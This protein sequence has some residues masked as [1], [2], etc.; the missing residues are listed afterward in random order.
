[1]K[2]LVAP[3]KFK[4][5]LTAPQAAGAIRRGLE[6]A[7]AHAQCREMPIAD[8]GE[9]TAEVLCSA[10]AGRWTIASA[11][12]PIGRPIEAGYAWLPGGTAVIAM[13][14]ASGLW[15]VP[16]DKRDILRA[17]TFGT[18]ELMAHA[19]AR[20]ARKIMLGL[21]G[22]ATN[23]GGVGAAA[24]CG[25][26][27]MD[28]K[29]RPVDPLPVAFPRLA[30]VVRPAGD[31]PEVVAM[32]DVTNPLLGPR[33][34]TWTYGPQKGG[35]ARTL[36]LLEEALTLL[37]GVVRKDL[38]HNFR[39]VPGAGAA[40]GMGFGLMSFF[41]ARICSG[42]ET[43]AAAIGLESAILESDLV[44]TGEGCLDGQTLEGKGPAGVA[45]LARKNGRPV[46]G[47]AGRICD[48]DDLRQ[49]FDG[50]YSIK[51]D[52]MPLEVAIREAE[53]L[54]ELKVAEAAF[55][56]FALKLATL[57]DLSPPTPGALSK[58]P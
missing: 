49:I 48:L 15:C 19:M 35:D 18:G 40:G 51:E 36:P 30:G 26:R 25:Y 50:V 23:D 43:V 2:I 56:G 3:D 9:G 29:G 14:A 58:F 31:F 12:D 45:A 17:S 47:F 55:N 13:S 46:I 54:L 32:C 7:L 21:G 53:S 22:S 6:R 39:E 34:A 44:I 1:M 8:G 37:A 10:L 33:G 27:F 28:R 42:F 52:A 16:P 38:G 57:E 20:G 5:S 41:G 11:H 24:A 4:G